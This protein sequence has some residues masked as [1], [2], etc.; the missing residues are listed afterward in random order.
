VS[1][2]LKRALVRPVALVRVAAD[3][4]SYRELMRLRAIEA[5]TGAGETE[6]ELRIG[7]LNG[8]PVWVREGTAD[9]DTLWDVFVHGYHVPPARAQRR[10]MHLVW[11]LGANIGLTMADMALRWPEAR[12][13][14]VEL[15]ADNAALARRNFEPWD[16][17]CELVEAA[18][19]PE[20]G[21][22]WYHRW[23]GATSAYYAHAPGGEPQ[24]PVVPTLSL[25]T[26]LDRCGGG[27]V[28]YVKMDVEGAE[29]ELLTRNTGW[30]SEVACIKVETHGDYTPD[31]CVADLERLGFEARRDRRHEAA[32]VG[33]R[34]IPTARGDG[35]AAGDEPP[36]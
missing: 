16:D 36:G 5:H 1:S 21:E 17:R 12:I 25:D 34:D 10:G 33:L 14:G 35:G 27:P 3:R 30:A 13:V 15:D 18:A 20:D 9:V 8:R 32:V 7:R 24:G 23:P 6:V 19:W 11:D 29:R 31:D 26:L 28:A 2:A 4:S 22:T